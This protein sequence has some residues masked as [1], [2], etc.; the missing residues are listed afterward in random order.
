MPKTKKWSKERR[1]I[2]EAKQAAKRN[3]PPPSPPIDEANC[4]TPRPQSPF[5]RLSNELARFHS[6][7]Q[8]KLHDLADLFRS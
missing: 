5:M 8:L 7:L 2:F 6:D 4:L 3:P 1:R